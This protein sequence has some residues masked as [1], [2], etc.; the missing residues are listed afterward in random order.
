MAMGVMALPSAS[1]SSLDKVCGTK[2]TTIAVANAPTPASTRWQGRREVRLAALG[3]LHFRA[4]FTRLEHALGPEDCSD[5]GATRT[6]I[7]CAILLK[8]ALNP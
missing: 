1:L 7:L 2:N 6:S 8:T 4:V 5:S 3:A